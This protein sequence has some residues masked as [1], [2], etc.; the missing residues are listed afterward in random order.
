MHILLHVPWNKTYVQTFQVLI[1]I[2]C[3][4]NELQG[5]TIAVPVMT[6]VKEFRNYCTYQRK[7]HIPYVT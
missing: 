6:P 3:D 5:R 7:N 4:N 2:H 1:S